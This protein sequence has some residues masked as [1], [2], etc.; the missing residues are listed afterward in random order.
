MTIKKKIIF[1]LA[2]LSFLLISAS[3][4]NSSVS[5]HSTSESINAT[6]KISICGNFIAEGGEDCDN[7]DLNGQTC[8]NLGYASGNLSCD[9]ACDFDT[10]ACI[11][12]T[13]TPTP[14]PTATPTIT[15][16]PTS[17]LTPTATPTPISTLTPTPTSTPA[18]SDSEE[19]VVPAATETPTSIPTPL[20]LLV[21]TAKTILPNPI[22]FFDSD[23]SGKI[24]ITEVF[25]VVK[26]WVNEWKDALVEEIAVAEN[27]IPE[28][29]K[30]KRCDINNDNKCNLTD[31]SI[32][33]F[34]IQK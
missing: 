15:P 4:F 19:A 34:Y 33:L 3:L 8:I 24:E 7:S 12:P 17:T 13:P 23:K 2:G 25:V 27:K 30:I 28:K 31:L 6:I 16:T 26:N 32:L 18:P 29:K 1:I 21:P 20:S 11:A 14:I 22:A 9:I 5:G 10:S